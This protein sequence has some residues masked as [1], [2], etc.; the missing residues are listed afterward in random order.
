MEEPIATK[1]FHFVY[2]DIE[3]GWACA[4]V[5]DGSDSV[6]MRVSYLHD[7]LDEMTR[8]VV[9]LLEGAREASCVF[10]DEPGEHLWRMQRNDE[11]LSLQVLWF[12][13]WASWGFDSTESKVVFST[14]VP[15]K[16]FATGIKRALDKIINE[17]GIEGY[18]EAWINHDFP[19]EQYDKLK[20]LLSLE[21]RKA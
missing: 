6:T 3:H 2:A 16:K 21:S 7:S 20:L 17:M 4:S 15:L 1:T 14:V 18:K 9:S 19:I 12:N 10:L 11:H 5:S 13:D 8:A